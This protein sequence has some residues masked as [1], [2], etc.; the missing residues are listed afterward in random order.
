MADELTEREGSLQVGEGRRKSEGEGS[1]THRLPC[2]T[3]AVDSTSS[4][5]AN[6]NGPKRHTGADLF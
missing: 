3:G 5:R 6:N 4:I 2:P 1:A